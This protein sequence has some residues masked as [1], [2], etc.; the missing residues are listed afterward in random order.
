MGVVISECNWKDKIP[1]SL[2]GEWLTNFKLLEGVGQ[3][4]YSRIVIPSNAESLAMDIIGTGDA[5]A[6]MT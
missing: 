3:L 2:R 4:K 1:D 6:K 5:S